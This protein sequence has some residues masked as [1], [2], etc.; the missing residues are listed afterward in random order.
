M[1]ETYFNRSFFRVI[2]MLQSI[3]VKRI[4]P[5]TPIE[6]AKNKRRRKLIFG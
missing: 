3:K 6:T 1:K 4:K 2:M 5:S